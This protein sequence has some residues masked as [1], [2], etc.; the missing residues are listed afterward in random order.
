M[1]ERPGR[2]LVTGGAGLLGR[3]LLRTAPGGVDLHA[4]QRHTPAVGA[5]A[6][7]VELSDGAAVAALWARL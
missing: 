2:V 1:A 4:T 6:H 5:E 7:A 3:A